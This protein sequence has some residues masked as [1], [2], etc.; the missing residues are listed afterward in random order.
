[1][2]KN[3]WM[4]VHS[5]LVCVFFKE[6]VLTQHIY[7]APQSNDISDFL[8]VLDKQAPTQSPQEF[9]NKWDNDLIAV[10]GKL[11]THKFKPVLADYV[12]KVCVLIY[13]IY[14]YIIYMHIVLR[15]DS[16]TQPR[17]SRK[18]HPR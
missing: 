3:V 15:V 2:V 7:V 5:L 10:V 8:T 11:F 16:L 9:F 18:L 13:N 12:R 6:F 4:C 14:I 17:V 1:M